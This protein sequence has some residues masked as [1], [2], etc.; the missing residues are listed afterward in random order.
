MPFYFPKVIHYYHSVPPPTASGY[1]LAI[2]AEVELVI[3]FYFVSERYT[4]HL[5][6][7]PI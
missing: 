2:L 3:H 1:V 5:Q 4:K 7:R 6:E